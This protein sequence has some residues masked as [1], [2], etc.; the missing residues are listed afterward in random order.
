MAWKIE[1]ARGKRLRTAHNQFVPGFM[2]FPEN[3]NESSPP[4]SP[5]N[6][7]QSD[8]IMVSFSKDNVGCLCI[9]V[10]ADAFVFCF[11]FCFLIQSNSKQT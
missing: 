1:K 9:L 2:H 4:A 6:T 11:C 5:D 7:S 10:V 3:N 8:E